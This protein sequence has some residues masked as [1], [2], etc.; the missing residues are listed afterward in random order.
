MLVVDVVWA[1]Y[2]VIADIPLS[3]KSEVVGEAMVNA[4]IVVLHEGFDWW[5][6]GDS[7]VAEF[8]LGGWING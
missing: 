3:F 4:N 8:L 2:V 5:V 6:R 7:A 1:Y